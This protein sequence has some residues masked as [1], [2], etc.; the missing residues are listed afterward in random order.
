MNDTGINE[1]KQPNS[2]FLLLGSLSLH[3]FFGGTAHADTMDPF[4][5]PISSPLLIGVY[6]GNDKGTG[7]NSDGYINGLVQQ[8]NETNTTALPEELTLL[9]KFETSRKGFL[10][11]GHWTE[12]WTDADDK[13][14]GTPSF[15][16]AFT[17][18]W[19]TQ[20]TWT[21]TDN[22]LTSPVYFSVK[23][24]NEFALYYAGD[25]SQVSWNTHDYA[26]SLS[27]ISF[28]TAATTVTPPETPDPVPE[29]ATLLL[30]GMGALGLARAGRRHFT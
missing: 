15:D 5:S 28:W 22:D 3:G 2:Y 29:P 1:I 26:H 7:P 27:H 11:W 18:M 19:R 13:E 25:L 23:A 17:D 12:K 9:G 20:G 30:L 8:Y 4:S 14:W 24:A 6:Q 16:M 10:W 21:L